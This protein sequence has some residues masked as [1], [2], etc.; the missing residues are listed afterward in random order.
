MPADVYAILPFAP[1]A[2]S[3]WAEDED[4]RRFL[5]GLFDHPMTIIKPE[6]NKSTSTGDDYGDYLFKIELSSIREKFIEA[7]RKA[8]D[9]QITHGSGLHE[10]FGG[11]LSPL[12]V[13]RLTPFDPEAE[14]HLCLSIKYLLAWRGLV[15]WTLSESWFY[16][17]AHVLEADNAIEA[18]FLTASHSMYRQALQLLRGYLEDLTVALYFTGDRP[19]YD[20]WR[21]GH[22]RIPNMRGKRGLVERL[23]RGTWLPGSAT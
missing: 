13:Q 8:I 5:H 2:L 23:T 9:S 12:A 16:S 15:N 1:T 20:Q 18:S 17:L 6:G 22:H 4:V 21:T 3:A 14:L 19:S 7:L 11:P 10:A